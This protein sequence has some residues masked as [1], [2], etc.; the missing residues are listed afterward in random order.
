M[1]VVSL[2]NEFLAT[3]REIRALEQRLSTM[4]LRDNEWTRLG[5]ERRRLVERQQG[6]SV[7]AVR[8]GVEVG[9]TEPTPAEQLLDRMR[10]HGPLAVVEALDRVRRTGY[11][12]VDEP[13][14]PHWV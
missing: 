4:G 7:A 12:V 2:I 3:G 14:A 11:Q 5:V 10:Q 8:A 13:A 9:S 1:H 6:E